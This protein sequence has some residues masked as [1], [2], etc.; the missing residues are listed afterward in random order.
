MQ[1]RHEARYTG[2][3][4]TII[5]VQQVRLELQDSDPIL[6]DI[7]SLSNEDFEVSSMEQ[8]CECLGK[9]SALL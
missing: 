9:Y 3:L 1:V 7:V 8:Y 4:R 2:L 6:A 5:T